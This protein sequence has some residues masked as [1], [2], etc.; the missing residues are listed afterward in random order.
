MALAVRARRKAYGIL[1]DRVLAW[2]RVTS[3]SHLFAK[4]KGSWPKRRET[5]RARNFE[6][7]TRLTVGGISEKIL[8]T[9]GLLRRLSVGSL[10]AVRI[11]L[12]LATIAG[13]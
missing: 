1:G 11:S 2:L 7:E 9:V 6:A 12:G 8:I 4:P 3:S 13:Y 5:K 10:D